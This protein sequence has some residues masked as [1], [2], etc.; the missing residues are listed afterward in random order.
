MLCTCFIIKRATGDCK[1]G[2]WEFPKHSISVTQ[3]KCIKLVNETCYRKWYCSGLELDN[4]PSQ[5]LSNFLWIPYSVSQSN[6]LFYFATLMIHFFSFMAV[7]QCYQ[8]SVWSLLLAWWQSPHTSSCCDNQLSQQRFG[9][10]NCR[11]C[12]GFQYR[13][14]KGTCVFT[15]YFIFLLVISTPSCNHFGR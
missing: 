11:S 1:K 12:F 6:V 8:P 10:P 9:T 7:L 3:V 5:K 15:V 14:T 4:S 2:L 13:K